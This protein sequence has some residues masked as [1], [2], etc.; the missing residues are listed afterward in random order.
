LIEKS[1]FTGSRREDLALHPTVKPSALVADDSL[2]IT[3]EQTAHIELVS[4]RELLATS[5]CD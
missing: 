1:S 2:T 4:C 3:P 5:I